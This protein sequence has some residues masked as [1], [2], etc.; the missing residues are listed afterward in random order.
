M[1]DPGD[2]DLDE[3]RRPRLGW[4]TTAVCIAV[5]AVA[6]LA[7]ALIASAVIG[8]DETVGVGQLTQ[9]ETVPTRSFTRFDGSTTSMADYRGQK[10]VVNFFS[11]TC[12]PCKREMP[13]FERAAREAG[14]EVTFLGIDVQDTLEAGRAMVEQTGV[15]YDIGQDPTGRLFNEF[16]G[17]VLPFT[18]FVAADGTILERETGRLSLAELKRTISANLLGGG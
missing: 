17:T 6:A 13:D 18:V 16:G 12:V 5:A 2:D 7:S 15:T 8:P 4:R 1:T 3:R 9:A 14:E 10:L 11:S